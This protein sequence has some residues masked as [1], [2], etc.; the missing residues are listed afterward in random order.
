M[1]GRS[2]VAENRELAYTVWRECGQNMEMTLRKLRGEHGMK[3]SKPTL[4][5]WREKYDWKGR[6]ARAEA[7][8]RKAEAVRELSFEEK[9]IADLVRQKEKYEQYFESLGASPPDNQA[10]YAYTGI[11]KAIIDIKKKLKVSDALKKAEKDKKMSK[12]ELLKLIRE[13]VYGL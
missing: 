10:T 13:E 12:D 7:E 4:Y 11:V 3:L 8:E 5:A 2:F 6:A 1:A 9:M